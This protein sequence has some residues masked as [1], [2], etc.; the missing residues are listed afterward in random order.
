MNPGPSPLNNRVANGIADRTGWVIYQR[1]PNASYQGPPSVPGES[2]IGWTFRMYTGNSSSS[3][4]VLTGQPYTMGEWQHLAF[5]WNPQA[6]NGPSS[7]GSEQWSGIATAYVDGVAVATNANAT[8]A[9]NT[10]PTED[11][12]NHPPADLA[13]GSYNLASGLG[14]EFEG[15][16]AHL[17]IYS[18]LVLS[19]DQ[20][21][22]HYMTGTNAHP[23]TN[24]EALVFTAA[25][26]G[27]P[28]QLSNAQHYRDPICRSMSRP[29]SRAPTAARSVPWPLPVSS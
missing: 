29:I 14:E 26:Q 21:L 24:Y 10:N 27:R 9:A 25:A 19:A 22:A 20:V 17:A 7:S 3:A 2:G 6:D 18:N 8:Y 15:D 4:D 11:P 16:I 1:D 13:I 12:A 5:T 23:A 28:F